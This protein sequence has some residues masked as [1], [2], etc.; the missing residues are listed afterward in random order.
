ML[1]EYLNKSEEKNRVMI[2]C[3]EIMLE[4]FLFVDLIKFKNII[5]CFCI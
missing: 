2:Y 5:E 4:F 1:Y 3:F